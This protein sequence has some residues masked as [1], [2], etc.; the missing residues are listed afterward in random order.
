MNTYLYTYVYV[1]TYLYIYIDICKGA[2][3]CVDVFLYAY[4]YVH[5]YVYVFV[6][7]LNLYMCAWAYI[8]GTHIDGYGLLS[9]CNQEYARLKS[10]TSKARTR[11]MADPAARIA[12]L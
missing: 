4:V 9:T 2:F 7:S 12:T 1:Y 11:Q 3:A 6:C 10:Y 8:R 5:A